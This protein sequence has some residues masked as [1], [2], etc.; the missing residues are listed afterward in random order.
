MRR[1]VLAVLI[2]LTLFA[3]P[4]A[5]Q[6]P[7][8]TTIAAGQ[9]MAGVRVGANI[10]D[11]IGAFG[12]LYDQED[13]NSGKYTIYDWPLRPFAVFAEK[14]SGR[15]VLIIAAYSDVYRTDKGNITGGS[16]R[17]A[18]EAAYGS[19]FE[20]SDGQSVVRLIYD[21]Q[22]ITFNVAKQGAMS[23][24]VVQIIVFLPGQW[25]AITDGL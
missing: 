13:S 2:G 6:A 4:A 12:T 5:A 21:A 22:G 19:E 7:A 1:S 10:S 15:I 18:A 9:Q 16:E 20:A 23:G 11:A 17:A 3:V 24:R 25:K 14:E 8:N